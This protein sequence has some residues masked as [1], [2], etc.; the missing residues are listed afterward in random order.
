MIIKI[1][2]ADRQEKRK[3]EKRERNMKKN[4]TKGKRE[5]AVVGWSE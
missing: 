4:S 2:A 3:P 5:A 1:I